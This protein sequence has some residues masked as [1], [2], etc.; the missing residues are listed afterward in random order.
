MTPHSPRGAHDPASAPPR[1]VPSDINETLPPKPSVS[2]PVRP[3]AAPVPGAA[4]PATP[5]Q[6]VTKKMDSIAP[7]SGPARGVGP[8]ANSSGSYRLLK[9][10]GGGAFGD[11]WESLAPGNFPVA[12][13]VIHRHLDDAEAQREL[14]ALETMRELRHPYLLSTHACWAEGGRLH[15][16]MDLADSTLRQRLTEYQAQGKPGI[17]IQELF[18]YFWEAS[19]ALDYLHGNHVLH[20]DIKPDNL[21][22]MAGHVKVADFG[23]A[24]FQEG[25]GTVEASMVA[26]T[27]S[28]MAPEVWEGK[29]NERSDLYSLAASYAELRLGRRPFGG[30]TLADLMRQHREGAPDLAGLPDEERMVLARALSTERAGRYASCVEFATALRAALMRQLGALPAAKPP[31]PRQPLPIMT[32]LALMFIVGLLAV[33]LFLAYD[34]FQ[35]SSELSPVP[36]R[37]APDRMI[38]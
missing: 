37:P 19:E 22:L 12:V 21:L 25:G 23:L 9:R 7:P 27:A 6:A 34:W 11:V 16:A 3:Q 14:K 15:I 5:S 33:L 35:R 18:R 36:N 4:P 38:D 29:V 20:R 24:R 1:G 32:L 8:L 2:G 17:P 26:G 31:A 30:P 28:Y 10:L 13:K